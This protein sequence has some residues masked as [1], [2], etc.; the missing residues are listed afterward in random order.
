M[1]CRQSLSVEFVE[2]KEVGKGRER[3][4][5][6]QREM[7]REG[8]GKREA[9]TCLPRGREKDQILKGS[10]KGTFAH[11]YSLGTACMPDR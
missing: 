3:M 5:E 2:K 8:G 11:L 9:E 10:L 6:S 4:R 7:E 1:P